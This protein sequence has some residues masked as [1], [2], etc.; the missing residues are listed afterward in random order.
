MGFDQFWVSPPEFFE[1]RELNQSFAAVGAFT[2]GEVN[3][4]AGDRPVRVRSASVDDD[5]LTALGVPAAQGRL[6]ARRE[7]DVTGRA[8]RRASRRRC[9]RRL[10]SSRTSCGSRRSAAGRSSARPSTSTACAAK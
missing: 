7:T 2:T 5:L 9:R 10:R 6:F 4:T 8:R 1:F 3:L